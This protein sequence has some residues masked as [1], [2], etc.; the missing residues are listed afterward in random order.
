MLR[1]NCNATNLEGEVEEDADGAVDRELGECGQAGV[2]AD[3]KRKEV[4]E[5]R[6]RDGGACLRHRQ[7][8]PEHSG[9]IRATFRE[10]SGDAA[11]QSVRE[12]RE[13]D[14]PA[15]AIVRVNL[16]MGPDAIPKH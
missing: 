3:Q 14:V 2:G 1:N 5:G 10:H 6:Q 7:R 12:G 16:N 11:K 8:Q 9:N 15:S 4:G 13:M